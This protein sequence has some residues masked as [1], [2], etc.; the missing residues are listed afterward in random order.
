VLTSLLVYREDRLP[1][2]TVVAIASRLV[3]ADR[4][5][6]A[7]AGGLAALRRQLER[8]VAVRSQPGRGYP[9]VESLLSALIDAQRQAYVAHEELVA[10]EGALERT[11]FAPCLML[12]DP[13][14]LGARPPADERSRMF[15]PAPFDPIGMLIWYL[16]YRPWWSTL[17]TAGRMLHEQRI[18][19]REREE[20]LA[21]RSEIGVERQVLPPLDAMF[22]GG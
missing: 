11:S 17:D 2:A 8:A 7:A 13:P 15:W 1:A 6:L 12:P 4:E 10:A 21:K 5:L 22:V 20:E 3:T 9:G 14:R 18:V 19:L 16:R